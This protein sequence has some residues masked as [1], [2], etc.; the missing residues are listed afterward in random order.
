LPV[1]VT[2]AALERIAVWDEKISALY[3]ADEVGALAQASLSEAR[4]RAG[5]T[6]SPLDGVPITIKDN[7]P[8]I[9]TANRS[10]AAACSGARP[11]PE[12]PQLLPFR[13]AAAFRRSAKLSRRGPV[14]TGR[15]GV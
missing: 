14:S 4:W 9:G 11:T 8:V 15:V 3:V 13:A 10:R 7:I 2:R 12:G 1:E 5:E 6:L